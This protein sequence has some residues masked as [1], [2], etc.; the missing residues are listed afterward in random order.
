[1]TTEFDIRRLE[2]LL[3]E[4]TTALRKAREEAELNH[5]VSYAL[6]YADAA[7]AVTSIRQMNLSVYQGHPTE[8]IESWLHARATKLLE[9]PSVDEAL[10]QL[11]EA[12]W[13]ETTA[14][15]DNWSWS[16]DPRNPR[17]EP[18]DRPVNPYTASVVPT[19]E[20]TTITTVTL[21]REAVDARLIEIES[22]VP[23]IRE[24][25]DARV[26]PDE[27]WKADVH[28]HPLADDYSTYRW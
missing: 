26:H 17:G 12:V 8:N 19:R 27:N 1:M 4:T 18:K 25:Y 22:T 11:K 7:T 20:P 14:A 6:G 2:G 15:F 9:R 23:G 5:D 28:W 10:R 24:A 16:N 21:T 3:A 13:E